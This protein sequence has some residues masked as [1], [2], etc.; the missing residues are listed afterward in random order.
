MT[1]YQTRHTTKTSKKKHRYKKVAVG[2][3]RDA[4]FRRLTQDAKFLLLCLLTLPE[5]NICPGII[6]IGP[7][8]LAEELGWSKDKLFA[9][10]EEL[11]R[12]GIARADF[13]A[14]LIFLPNAMRFNEPSNVNVLLGYAKA[15]PEI[16]ECLLKIDAWNI[17]RPV[18]E[19]L[20]AKWSQECPPFEELLPKPLVEG[21]AEPFD[22]VSAGPLGNTVAVV[23]E[24]T[25]TAAR[26][27]HTH[28][29][30]T[31]SVEEDLSRVVSLSEKTSAGALAQAG[32]VSPPP[33]ASNGAQA[34]R[35]SAAPSSSTL[36]IPIP[37]YTTPSTLFKPPMENRVAP[38]PPP[39]AP[40]A[41]QTTPTSFPPALTVAP[42]SQ[43]SSS[44]P[45]PDRETFKGRFM[46][47]YQAKYNAPLIWRTKEDKTADE[48]LHSCSLVEV[49]RRATIMFQSPPTW[50][51]D[52]ITDLTT[53]GKNF[54]R[55]VVT[56]PKKRS[57]SHRVNTEKRNYKT[58]EDF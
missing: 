39:L 32:P 7:A 37:G 46:E 50:L 42:R 21:F 14:H 17:Y 44:A 20:I 33:L 26:T 8:A 9:V 53:L 10:F 15:W 18:V 31:V 13:N 54:N 57:R 40:I 45:H 25:A 11:H 55:L 28:T 30:A 51:Q 47:L 6:V 29:R 2:I 1:V 58:G 4:K 24:R 22:E 35:P 43:S 3:H 48:L 41:G 19:P 5:N 16:P 38:S 56:T 52:S 49:L 23:V 27:G 36:P 12:H 34:P